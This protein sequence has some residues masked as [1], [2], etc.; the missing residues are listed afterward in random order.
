VLILVSGGSLT[1]ALSASRGRVGERAGHVLPHTLNGVCAKA[2]VAG[3]F[4]DAFAAT[5]L[6]LDA[7]SGEFSID[8]ATFESQDWSKV[9]LGPG[10]AKSR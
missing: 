10:D 7:F 1:C 9:G 3:N 5:Q 8:A 2:E 4:Q 6:R